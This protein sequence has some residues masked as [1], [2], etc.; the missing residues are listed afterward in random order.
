MASRTSTPSPVHNP[1]M[2]I[3]ESKDELWKTM[4][5]DKLSADEAAKS[6]FNDDKYL[7]SRSSSSGRGGNGLVSS[8]KQQSRDEDNDDG[9]AAEEEGDDEPRA[10]S[11]TFVKYSMPENV[12]VVTG[13]EQDECLLQ[14]RA[15]LFRLGT[16]HSSSSS[17]GSRASSAESKPVGNEAASASVF[18]DIVQESSSSASSGAGAAEWVEVGIGPVKLL[19][20]LVAGRLVMRREEKKGGIGASDCF[21]HLFLLCMFLLPLVSCAGTKLLLN[22]RLNQFVSV[23]RQAEKVVRLICMNFA[24]EGAAAKKEEEAALRLHTYLLKTKSVQVRRPVCS[25]DYF[26]T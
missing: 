17:S 8:E 10:E 23:T 16:S 19:Q 1:F 3:V 4:A 2:T 5:K 18:A 9:D 6:F 7:L 13:E 12:T 14:V 22:V 24:D 21:P 15:K 11:P 20:S 26:H 25:A